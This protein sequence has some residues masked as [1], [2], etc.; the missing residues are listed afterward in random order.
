MTN[1]VVI[2]VTSNTTITTIAT[3]TTTTITTI[4]TVT[5]TCND[6]ITATF[7][8]DEFSSLAT[9]C[10]KVKGQLD[11]KRLGAFHL[12]RKGAHRVY[13]SDCQK[14]GTQYDAHVEHSVNNDL[15]RVNTDVT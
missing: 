9:T 7:D 1:Y 14:R 13:G 10:K 12:A 8:R 15:Q 5:I 3:T 4:T 6:T 2:L 11:G